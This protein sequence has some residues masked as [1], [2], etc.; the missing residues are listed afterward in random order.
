ML[1]DIGA[2]IADSA[3]I[4]GSTELLILMTDIIDIDTNNH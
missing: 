3:D 2:D 1:V 4:A